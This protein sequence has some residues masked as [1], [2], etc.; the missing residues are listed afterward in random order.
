[1]GRRSRDEQLE[2]GRVERE[3]KPK[4]RRRRTDT[5]APT[6]KRK[7]KRLPKV[8]EKGSEEEARVNKKVEARRQQMVEAA[9][10]AELIVKDSPESEYL[11]E[12]QHIFQSLQTMTRIAE[13]KYAESKSSKDIYALMAMYSQMRECIADM[14]TIQDMSHQS[15]RLLFDIVEPLIKNFGE[16]LVHLLWAIKK[17]I[18]DNVDDPRL[19]QELLR[20]IDESFAAQAKT[21]QGQAESTR[22]KAK[23]FFDA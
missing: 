7:R 9:I 13:T 16:T 10:E 2:V 22:M 6:P 14:R 4:R 11:S 18:S 21:I 20:N 17:A 1:M 8:I 12:Y 19:S 15:D 3:E 5:D 23:G